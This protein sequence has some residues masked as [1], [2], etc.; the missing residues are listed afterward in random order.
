MDIFQVREVVA[1]P[2]LFQLF[3]NRCYLAFQ[4]H[5]RLAFLRWRALVVVVANNLVV[6]RLEVVT[7]EGDSNLEEA[8]DNSPVEAILELT[9]EVAAGNQVVEVADN[10][11]EEEVTDN[12]QEE[13]IDIIVFMLQPLGRSGWP[14]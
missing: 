2:V 7:E 3:R 14:D 12:I 13:A 8:A 6:A 10:I 5:Q 11:L 9:L 1:S 4:Y